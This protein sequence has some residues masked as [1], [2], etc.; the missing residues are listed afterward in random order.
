MINRLGTNNNLYNYIKNWKDMRKEIVLL[1][2]L[3]VALMGTS[4][5]YAQVP[6]NTLISEIV[7][8]GASNAGTG[9]VAGFLMSLIAVLG[10]RIEGVKDAN[11]NLEPI[12]LNLLLVTVAI[13]G[14]VGFFAPLLGIGVEITI[15][16]VIGLT[17]I[18]NTLLRPVLAKWQTKGAVS[19]T[20]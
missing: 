10:R 13:A 6:D 19:P 11:G 2:L 14:S 8:I 7:N 16:A 1:P 12:K 3:V 18:V 4:L 9:A 15:P 17:W 5:A 20:N